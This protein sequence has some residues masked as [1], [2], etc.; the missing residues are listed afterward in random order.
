MSRSI[1]FG[2]GGWVGNVLGQTACAWWPEDPVSVNFD[3]TKLVTSNLAK[4]PQA[5]RNGQLTVDKIEVDDAPTHGGPTKLGPTF[6]TGSMINS[7]WIES[8]HWAALPGTNRPH[9]PPS[10]LLCRDYELTTVLY[11]TDSRRFYGFYAEITSEQSQNA[12]CSIWPA[13]KSLVPG[14]APAGSWW[15]NLQTSAHP[16]ESGFTEIGIGPGHPKK[17]ALFLDVPTITNLQLF[18]PKLPPAHGADFVPRRR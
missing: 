12:L 9:R 3:P 4:N 7:I 16:I 11:W 18:T 10:Y 15:I 6:P 13:G 14:Q 8:N 5:V 1:F 17:G 2:F